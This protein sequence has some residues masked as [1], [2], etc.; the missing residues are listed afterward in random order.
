MQVKGEAMISIPLFIIKKFGNKA[1]GRWLHSIS[2]QAQKVYSSP[3]HKSDWYPLKEMISNPTVKICELFY[4]N[5]KKGAWDCGRYSAEYGLK[6]IYKILVKLCSPNVLIK[7]GTSIIHNYYK[8]SEIEIDDFSKSYVIVHITKFPELD[9]YIEY[10]IGG[11]MER[12]IEIC[13]CKHV[14]ITITNSLTKND[15]Y[16]EYNIT[17]K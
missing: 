15:P 17:W 10:R 16:T 14:S 11:W 8:P 5:S 12:A 2:P 9:N 7:K 13:G 3:I 1:Y 4:N 6:G